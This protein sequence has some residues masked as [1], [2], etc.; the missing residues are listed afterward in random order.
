EAFLGACAAGVDAAQVVVD[1]IVLAGEV[2]VERAL[3]HVGPLGDP[4]DAGRVDAVAVEKLGRSTL[5][6][7]ACSGWT[8]LRCGIVHMLNCTP[9]SL[10]LVKAKLCL[11]YQV[12]RSV[13]RKELS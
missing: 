10:H 6:S 5:D 1:E 4:F 9:I 2:L 7:F 11:P 8:R 3:G 12:N 13:S